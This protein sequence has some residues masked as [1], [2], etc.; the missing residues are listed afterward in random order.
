MQA[1]GR[2]FAGIFFCAGCGRR[3]ARPEVLEEIARVTRG[4]VIEADRLDEIVPLLTGLP[5][6]PPS[7][8]RLQIWSHPAV[9]AVMIVLLSVFWVG[10]KMIGLI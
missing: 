7:V 4:N 5:E 2:D 9:A 3:A 1:D 8:R 6:P 10:R